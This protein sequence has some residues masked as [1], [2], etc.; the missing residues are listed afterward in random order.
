MSRSSF[1]R[2]PASEGR[3]ILEGLWRRGFSTV[4]GTLGLLLISLGL[5]VAIWVFVT[6]EENPTRSGLFP[7][8]I[9]VQAVNV[10]ADIAVANVFPTVDVRIQARDD[11]WDD[12]TTANFRAIVDLN[13]LTAREQ[14]VP[15]RVE[16]D[17]ARGV[18]VIAVEP[19]AIT[20][21]L[22]DIVT[23]IVPVEPRLVGALPRG[24]AA[25]G[26]VPAR[27]TVEVSGPENLVDL[28]V[29]A[30]VDVNV[31]GLT[32]GLSQT[33]ELVA[34]GAGGGE[35]RG[36]AIDPPDIRV[37]VEIEQTT[38]TR[39]VPLD[40]ELVGE[41]APGYRV[42]GVQIQPGVFT[43]E[44]EFDALQGVDGLSLGQVL[45]DGVRENLSVMLTPS[46]PPGVNAA[47]PGEI[48]VIISIMAIQG[49][50]VVT[51]APEL[52]GV[53]EGLSGD[54][55]EQLVTVVLDGA[56]PVLNGLVAGDIRAEID[57]S[58]LEEGASEVVVRIVA[59]SEVSVREVRP[60]ELT[61]TLELVPTEGEG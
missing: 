48:E 44:G 47:S 20:V 32:V 50:T 21:N 49:S 38:L 22:E 39:V 34:R 6:E 19:P 40:V 29:S 8:R 7:G 37:E 4:R 54:L 2:R 23:R 25:L 42:S 1:P 15:V 53:P 57:A 13:G 26:A 60:S 3:E 14:T 9:E 59:P 56:I 51:V 45:L 16:V 10:G 24:F 46:L 31:T 11:R 33:L 43:I 35:I 27:L 58:G 36:V 12:L 55:G 28:V 17:D 61:V 30:G 18:R 41:P 5:G 52:M